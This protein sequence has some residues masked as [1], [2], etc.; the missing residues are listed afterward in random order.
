MRNESLSPKKSCCAYIRIALGVF[1]LFALAACG[2]SGTAEPRLRNLV[3]C[4]NP[5]AAAPSCSLDGYSLADD[6]ALRAKLAGCAVTG[7]HG[8]PGTANLPWELDLSA[9]SV[10]SALAPLAN[11]TAINGVDYLVD[12]FDP[13]CSNLL[14]KLTE[15]PAGGNRMPLSGPFWSADEIDCFRSYLHEVSN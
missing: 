10:E 2:E 1:A 11:I 6:S 7:C 12:R 13:D 4:E 14:T 5:E 15:Q 3:F 8:N 9:P